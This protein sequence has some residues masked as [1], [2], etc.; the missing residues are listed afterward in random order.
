[1]YLFHRLLND[2]EIIATEN[3]VYDYNKKDSMY[4]VHMTG[5]LQGKSGHVKVTAKNIGGEA[6]TECNLDIKGRAPTFIE[7]PIKCTILEGTTSVFRCR[8]DG[9]PEPKVEWSKGVYIF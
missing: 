9:N 7:K 5:D 4:T 8:V 3:I 6:S 2:A 1:M